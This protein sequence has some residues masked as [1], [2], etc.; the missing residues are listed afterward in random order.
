MAEAIIVAVITGVFAL[1]GTYLTVKSGNETIMNELRTSQAVQ[2]TEISQ[3]RQEIK[4]IKDETKELK[5]E[6][7]KHNDFAVRVPFLEDA[8]RKLAQQRQ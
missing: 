3:I 6:V 1:L 8:V 7:Q 4:E 2:A 5:T